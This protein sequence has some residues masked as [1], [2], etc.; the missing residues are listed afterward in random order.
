MKS[1][2]KDNQEKRLYRIIDFKNKSNTRNKKG[3]LS[4]IQDTTKKSNNYIEVRNWINWDKS[5]WVKINCDNSSIVLDS[6]TIIQL[7]DELK[8]LSNRK[9]RGLKKD[10]FDK[11][12]VINHKSE[13]Y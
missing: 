1:I 2:I 4:G 10:S 9:E 13:F 7:A 5:L 11:L 8:R 3:Y 6:G 12:F